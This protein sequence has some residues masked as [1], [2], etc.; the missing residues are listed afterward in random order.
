MMCCWA[1]MSDLR[2]ISCW[3]CSVEARSELGG[4]RAIL[5]FERGEKWEAILRGASSTVA[6]DS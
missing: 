4:G 2:V 6:G 3:P 5:R 1:C